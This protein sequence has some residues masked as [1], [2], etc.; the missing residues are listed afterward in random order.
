MNA[1]ASTTLL[2][3]KLLFATL[4]FVV[5]SMLG[6]CASSRG[7]AQVRD[8]ADESA[9]LD[10]YA[11]LTERFRGSYAREQPYLSAAADAQAQAGERERRALYPDLIAIHDSVVLYMQTLGKL[12]G[13]DQFDLKPQL[14]SLGTGIKAWPETGLSDRHVNAYTNLAALLTRAVTA[15]YQEKS[16]QTMVRDG[17]EPMQAL[18][19]AMQNL[20]RYYDKIND[21]EQA[22]VLGLLDVEIPFAETPRD[23]L[24]AVLAKAH[25]QTKSSEYR[26]AG[27]RHTLAAKHVAAITAAHQTLMEHIDALDSPQARAALARSNEAVHAAAAALA[28][29]TLTGGAP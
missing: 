4:L 15:P 13:S 29:P 17:Y 24:L 7:L 8:F 27:L 9:K 25:R 21:N 26:L 11:E 20:L 5:L 12:A 28:T 18:L 23:R 19:D 3:R 1:T 10:G 2:F 16:V 14:K 6:G 22:I